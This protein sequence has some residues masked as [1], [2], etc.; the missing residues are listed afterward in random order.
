MGNSR[1]MLLMRTVYQDRYKDGIT[2]DNPFANKVY[3]TFVE[4]AKDYGIFDEIDDDLGIADVGF[5]NNG[6]VIPE[7]KNNVRKRNVYL[8]HQFLGYQG[9]QDPNIG[10]KALLLTIDALKRASASEIDVIIPYEPYQRQDRKLRSRVPISGK[11][12]CDLMEK[13]GADRVVT[14][15]MHAGQIQGFFNI[16]VDNLEALPIFLNLI[17]TERG[18]KPDDYVIVSPDAGGMEKARYL[19]K[20]LG[21]SMPVAMVDK[22]RERPGEAK[23]MNIVG[24]VKGKKARV[25]DDMADTAKTLGRGAE[26]LIRNGAVDV[27]MYATHPVFSPYKDN[28]TKQTMIAEENLMIPEVEEVYVTDTIVRPPEYFIKWNKIKEVTASE[29]FG[30]AICRIQKGESVRSLFI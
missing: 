5:F 3:K 2:Y 6:E 24:D 13:A 26:A 29:I 9:E 28:E 12:M 15:D 1:G 8:I 11:L 19:A 25:I 16:P 30:D 27:R 7:I 4:K 23:V 21:E 14:M 20:K 18:Y 17:K 10:Y 22:R